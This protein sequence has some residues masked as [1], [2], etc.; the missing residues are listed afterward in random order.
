M[1]ANTNSIS[2]K[3]YCWFYAKRVKQLPNNLCP[4]FWKLVLAYIL[5]IPYAIFSLPMIVFTELLDKNYSNG[6]N[7][8]GERLGLS[9]LM[10]VAV[11]LASVMVI[12]VGAFFTTYAK[13]GFCTKVVPIGILLWLVAIVIGGYQGIK[14]WREYI[15][16]SRIKYDENG[17]RIW[18]EPKE[19]TPNMVIEFIKAKYGEYCPRIE[20]NDGRQN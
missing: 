12:A 14:A 1:K 3:L 13:Y 8:T 6:D 4:Y 7:K 20:W 5:F 16:N 10:Y 2:A 9:F 15:I 18:E 19:K 17:Y 11:F